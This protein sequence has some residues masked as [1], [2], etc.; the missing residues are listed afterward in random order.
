MENQ[1]ELMYNVS[2]Y[3]RMISY[4]SDIFP[5]FFSCEKRL[6]PGALLINLYH[7]Y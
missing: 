1:P 4:Y 5:A 7:D 6:V 2:S 3:K